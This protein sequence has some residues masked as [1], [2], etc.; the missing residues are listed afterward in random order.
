MLIIEDHEEIVE[1]VSLVLQIRWPQAKIVSTDRGEEGIDLVEKES[2]DV[3][4]LDL[5]LP[6]IGGFEVLKS[7]RLFSAVPIVIL[8]VRGEEADIVKGLE[9]GADEY[10]TK[11]FRQLELL[12]RVKAVVR[13][14]SVMEK[15][16]SI[17]CGPF[18]LDPAM[19]TV[20]YGDRQI[21]LT[22]SQSIILLELMRHAGNV[23]THANLAEKLWG[24]DYP[25]AAA[26]LK[27]H[28]RHLRK[29]IEPE[30]SHP[31]FIITKPGLGYF[32]AKPH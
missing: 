29:K 23:I 6:D 22:R 28:I 1:A 9:L 17:I 8:T 4:I 19:R 20:I 7:V 32:F 12:A 26:S 13:R 11:P 3:V 25:D 18:L 14:G 27:V 2:P 31:R 24:D 30:S 21:S 15:D 5:G 10:I 16:P